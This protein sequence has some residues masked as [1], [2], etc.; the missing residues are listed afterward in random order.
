ML[1]S[2]V[3]LFQFEP[4]AEN[5]LCHDWVYIIITV[6]LRVSDFHLHF[7]PPPCPP[8]LVSF[9]RLPLRLRFPPLP[10]MV[11]SQGTQPNSAPS[12]PFT[13][14]SLNVAL[15]CLF[16]F[17]QELSSCG[18]NKKEKHSSAPNV[19]AF[20]RRFNQVRTAAAARKEKWLSG[21]EQS[22]SSPPPTIKSPCQ[23]AAPKW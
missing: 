2:Y 14:H 23:L 7:F 17:F 4:G 3:N 1:L 22:S 5:G 15:F 8:H 12:A 20:T 18:W 16:V 21:T 6:L 11:G 13:A 9:S 10:G 19:V